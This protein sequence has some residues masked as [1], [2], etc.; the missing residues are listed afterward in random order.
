MAYTTQQELED[1]FG[2]ATLIALT[3]RAE[4]ATGVID[5]D[6]VARAIAD[7]DALIDG[8][9]AARYALPM[10]GVPDPLGALSRA[11]TLYN[12]H[13]YEPAE[14][15]VRDYKDALAMLDKI[16]KGQVRLDAEGHAPSPSGAG[17]IRITETDR[18]FTDTK[19]KGFI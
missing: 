15:I 7:A 9:L 14:K 2:T 10:E 13:V 11:I 3:D 12:L 16:S 1:R 5:A 8:F 19:M 18:P 6:I 17:R 4:L